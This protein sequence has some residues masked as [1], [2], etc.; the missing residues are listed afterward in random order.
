MRTTAVSTFYDMKS[1]EI[2]IGKLEEELA[3]KSNPV[4]AADLAAVRS[5]DLPLNA[6]MRDTLQ[7]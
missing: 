4:Q 2:Q 5:E 6:S 7:K 1:L 3:L